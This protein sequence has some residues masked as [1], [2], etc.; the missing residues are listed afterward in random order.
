MWLLKFHFQVSLLCASAIFGMFFIFWNKI[1]ENGWAEGDGK[2]RGL[3]AQ[4]GRFLC[5]VC[6]LLIASAIPLVNIA[7]VWKVLEMATKKNGGADNGDA[8]A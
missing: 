2:K 3:L 4:F 1:I 8:D 5:A 7:A 6:K